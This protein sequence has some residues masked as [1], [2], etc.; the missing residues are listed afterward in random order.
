LGIAVILCAGLLIVVI[1]RSIGFVPASPDAALLS[2]AEYLYANPQPTLEY[3]QFNNQTSA[4]QRKICYWAGPNKDDTT[5]TSPQ[6]GDFP[7]SI[8]FVNGGR[9]PLNDI[10]VEIRTDQ[11]LESVHL[12]PCVGVAGLNAGV[13]LVELHLKANPW[14]TPIIYQWAVMVED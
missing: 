13:H 11:E 7:S 8:L 3:V 6:L 1:Y 10:H 9:V 4:T 14:D 12:A 2:T 5:K